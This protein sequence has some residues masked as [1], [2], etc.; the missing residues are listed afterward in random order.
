MFCGSFMILLFDIGVSYESL[1]MFAPVLR[2][3]KV[4]MAVVMSQ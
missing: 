1:A 4:S 3:M 2:L